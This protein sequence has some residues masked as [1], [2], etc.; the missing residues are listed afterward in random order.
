[1]ERSL[2]MLDLIH[3]IL[4]TGI[5][6]AAMT[7]QKAK[8]I[9]AE[10]E[11]KGEVSSEDGKKLAEELVAKARK[12]SQEFRQSVNDEVNGVLNKLHLATRAD[13]EALEKRIEQL[14]CKCDKE[15]CS[16]EE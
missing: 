12:Q 14:E 11:K 1:M 13:V 15:H 2:I 6:F 16:E 9:A 10:L 7:E 4:Y 8:E 5:G 3:K